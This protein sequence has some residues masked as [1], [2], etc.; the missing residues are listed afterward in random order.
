MSPTSL[1]AQALNAEI[2]AF[3]RARRGRA[4]TA[5]ERRRYERLRAEW[6]AAVRRARRRTA[7]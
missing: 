1:D 4:L 7:A 6:L 5:A 2:R 3:L